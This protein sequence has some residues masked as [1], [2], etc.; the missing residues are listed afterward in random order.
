MCLKPSWTSWCARA[1]R[2]SPFRCENSCV[3]F[4]PN[5]QPAP[6]GLTAHVSTSGG[7]GGG[8]TGQHREGRGWGEGW[9]AGGRRTILDR[10]RV[11][12]KA[13]GAVSRRTR[14]RVRQGR[15]AELTGSDHITSGGAEEGG[16]AGRVISVCVARTR[17]QGQQG[18]EGRS[19]APQKAPSCGIS[20]A[21]A[22][23]LIWSTV[24]MSGLRPP[25]TQST[26][27]SMSA[28][29]GRWSNT[30]QHAFQTDALPYFCWHS[31]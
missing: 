3:T 29:S 28:P 12:E 16:Q 15:P 30:W 23:V 4:A 19:D 9:L 31:S 27:P 24:R 20:C 6:R 13:G 25:W 8:E 5:S 21:R 22:I 2:L 1:I 11:E 7:A 26:W 18:A 17:A 14:D 10:G